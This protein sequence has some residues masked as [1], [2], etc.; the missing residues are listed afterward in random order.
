MISAAII[1]DNFGPYHVARLRTSATVC[2]L[3]AIE[4]AGVSGTYAWNAVGTGGDFRRVTLFEGGTSSDMAR[5]ELYRRLHAALDAA[6]AQVIL[7]PGWASPAAWGAFE[8]CLKNSTPIVVMSDS[9][10]WDEPRSPW[11]E[12]V[13]SNL[14]AL[15]S[16]AFVA[17][18]RHRDYL[19]KLGMPAGRVFLGYDVVD[20][21]Y[22][23]NAA[24][25]V[26]ARQNEIR[27][28][29]RLPENYFLA[30][31]RFIGKKN[32]PRLL[33]AYARYRRAAAAS[34]SLVLL[35][36]GPLRPQLEKQLADLDLCD[37]V[38]MPGFRQYAELPAYYALAGAFIQA[39]TEEP[40]GLVVNEAMAS[41]LPVIVSHRCGCLPELVHENVNGFA[42]DPFD[43]ESLTEKLTR[44][45]APDFPRAAFAAKSRE[46]VAQWGPGRFARGLLQSAESALSRPV[47]PAPMINRTILSLL[48]RR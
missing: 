32:L 11:K 42:F 27:R 45:S 28:E 1:Y 5:P 39:S 24:R 15:G 34:W 10:E 17:G 16:S 47:P 31:A 22:F 2:N 37:H 20:N 25:A 7:I 40:W 46:I 36:D 29:H 3:T 26:L 14:V 41:G 9:T 6:C 48:A 12:W 35:G 21:A 13:K 43:V 38:Q 23:E 44:V 8:W 33:E 30:S 4:I 18:A 19:V